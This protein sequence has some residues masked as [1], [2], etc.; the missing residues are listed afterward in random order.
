[1]E[2]CQSFSNRSFFVLVHSNHG[3]VS[4]PINS[5]DLLFTSVSPSNDL[6]SLLPTPSPAH[7]KA[8]SPLQLVDPT[9][10][11]F[12]N[13]DIYT[14]SS[15]PIPHTPTATIPSTNQSRSSTRL[16]QLLATKSPPSTSA[17]PHYH[18]E[19]KSHT[20]T[21]DDLSQVAESPTTTHLSPLTNDLPS[22]SKRRRNYSQT[23]GN[24]ADILLKQILGRQAPFT[25]NPTD[26][27]TLEN[28]PLWSSP[29]PA[30]AIK[31]ESNNSD[32]SSSNPPGGANKIRSDMYL[33]VSRND[34][35]VK[36]ILLLLIFFFFF[37]R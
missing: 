30:S 37:E 22:P 36:V 9:S 3:S 33:R 27:S 4:S 35:N 31:T 16:R 24:S 19:N 25:T 29:G 7:K 15:S 18:N 12:S 13:S 20:N 26:N 2:F 1:M 28:N 6:N 8:S 17:S 11:L 21:F 14:T 34:E 32:D 23:N 10:L 5:F